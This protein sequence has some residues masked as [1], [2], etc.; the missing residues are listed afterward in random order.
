LQGLALLSE[1]PQET[2]KEVEKGE[3]NPFWNDLIANKSDFGL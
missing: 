2:L 1:R 3:V